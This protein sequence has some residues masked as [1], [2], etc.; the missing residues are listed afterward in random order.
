[1][2]MKIE[3]L[4]SVNRALEMDRPPVAWSMA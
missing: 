4:P 2:L 1:M 3:P